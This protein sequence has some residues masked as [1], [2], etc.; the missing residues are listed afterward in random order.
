MEEK[1]VFSV[2]DPGTPTCKTTGLRD[3]FIS[4]TKKKK[5]LNDLK[6]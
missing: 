5:D 4:Y 6:L 2:S 3:F 1:T